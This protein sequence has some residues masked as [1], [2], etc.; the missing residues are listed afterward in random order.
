MSVNTV[1][2][3]MLDVSK[4]SNECHRSLLIITGFVP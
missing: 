2:P 3:F 4:E 1:F